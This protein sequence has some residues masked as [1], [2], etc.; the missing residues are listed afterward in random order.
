MATAYSPG[1]TVTG[2]TVHRV[3][4]ILPIKGEVRTSVGA[5]VVAEDVVAETFMPGDVQPINMANVLSMPPAD[6]EECLVK[7]E[8]ERVEI[9]EVLARTKGIFGMF[10][11]EYKS[12][13]SGTLETVSHVTGQVIVRGEPLPVQVLAYMSGEVVEILPGEG[14][15]IESE[16]AFIQGIFGIGGEAFGTIKMAGAS[17]EDELTAD[18]ITAEMK[19]CVVVG[20]GRIHAEAI[21]KAREV[22]V[23]ALVSGGLDDQ[24]LR[25]FLGYDLGVAITGS[26][27]LGITLVI[28]EGFGDISMAMRTFDLLRSHAGHFVSVNGATQIRAGVMRPEILIPLRDQAAAFEVG[29]AGHAAG[30]AGGGVLDVGKSVRIIR[31]PYFG[32]IGEVAGLPSEPRV[33]DSGSRARILEVTLSGDGGGGAGEVVVIPRANVEL[34]EG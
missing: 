6:V 12:K 7:K 34:I 19:G 29:H 26:E 5:Q 16:V 1:L 14:C 28:T 21:K 3:K 23:A 9:G 13:V 8:G 30:D 31:D 15:V 2:K 33:L 11:N 20:G 32:M 17:H 27:N 4:R 22:G 18:R 10:K 25:D 24:D